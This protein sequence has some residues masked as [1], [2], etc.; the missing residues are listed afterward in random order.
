[1]YKQ[2]KPRGSRACTVC[3]LRKIRCDCEVKLPCSNCE[4]TGGQ[5]KI[6][7][8]KRQRV[9]KI[10]KKKDALTSIQEPLVPPQNLY[11]QYGQ[12]VVL[13]PLQNGP[14]R[15]GYVLGH[16]IYEGNAPGME[17]APG[18]GNGPNMVPQGV[19]ETFKGLPFA[20]GPG[21]YPI[22]MHSAQVQPQPYDRMM[23][24]HAPPMYQNGRPVE[25]GDQEYRTVREQAHIHYGQAEQ[26]VRGLAP[27][28]QYPSSPPKFVQNQPT[29][30]AFG[31]IEAPKQ[32]GPPHSTPPPRYPETNTHGLHGTPS[33][34]PTDTPYETAVE[35]PHRT[36]SLASYLGV[37]YFPGD[38]MRNVS[39]TTLLP[40]LLHSSATHIRVSRKQLLSEYSYVGPS[41][42]LSHFRAD[43]DARDIPEKLSESTPAFRSLKEL[44]DADF[45][46][47]LQ[48]LA[49]RRAFLLPLHELCLVLI[50]SFFEKVYPLCPMINRET[51]L[52]HFNDPDVSKRPPLILT[53]LI[54]MAGSRTCLH[55]AILDTSGSSL[56]ASRIFYERMKALYYSAIV[57]YYD[58]DDE[59]GQLAFSYPGV[60][61]A[62]LA[63]FAYYWDVPGEPTRGHC[64]WTAEALNV[65]IGY[66]FHRGFRYTSK[67]AESRYKDLTTVTPFLIRQQC[68]YWRKMFW[69]LFIR[70]KTALLSYGRPLF[71]SIKN[72]D[73][74]VLTLEDFAKYEAGWTN[75][76]RDILLAEYSVH[77]GRLAELTEVVWDETYSLWNEL[78]KQ[79]EKRRR[80]II[81]QCNSIMME[82]FAQLSTSL[83][84]DSTAS[85]RNIFAASVG[86]HYYCLLYHIN[87]LLIPNEQNHKSVSWGIAFQ[88]AFENSRI[89]KYLVDERERDPQVIFPALTIY[90][91]ALAAIVLSLH[92]DSTNKVVALAAAR[93]ISVCLKFIQNW[94]THWPGVSFM[95]LAYFTNQ[96]GVNEKR[97][98]LADKARR[99]WQKISQTSVTWEQMRTKTIDINFL[100]NSNGD[101]SDREETD[102][103]PPA[104]DMSFPVH[105]IRTFTA[106]SRRVFDAAA[107]FCKRERPVQNPGPIPRDRE[108]DMEMDVLFGF[109]DKE[110]D[111]K[112]GKK[113]RGDLDTKTD[114]DTEIK[115]ESM[116][117]KSSTP[118]TMPH[119]SPGQENLDSI[120]DYDSLD[121]QYF[122]DLNSGIEWGSS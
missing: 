101:P 6:A 34:T 13:Q 63:L 24:M 113:T 55:P 46:V 73:V 61:T 87:R 20:A 107:L 11:V 80:Q 86:M 8:V 26:L 53:M 50:D 94:S 38:T 12:P 97:Y 83:K 39:T 81:T 10:S 78:F 92:M 57:I 48:V 37:A 67:V 43:S 119:I 105:R 18:M 111:L 16:P 106:Q 114:P 121:N 47:E 82:F 62:S 3:R 64:F 35:S 1:M 29:F 112:A 58:G 84:F 52:R 98:A 70:D 88:A 116:E 36:S 117:T 7:E 41:S 77:S 27:P 56:T 17:S 5:C 28:N 99:L 42:C 19:G 122:L 115:S 60:L 14:M 90:S 44:S 75:L 45:E 104:T 110:V 103:L 65:A 95:L 4:W 40:S 71:I 9:N 89:A 51:F 33:Q 21:G 22:L 120:Y 91:T 23:P 66:G 32:P 31:P 118:K 72:M 69:W 109:D 74:E 2:R 79:D 76:D 93:Q 102:D 85:S 68:F 100:L 30:T 25:P 96:L 59:P 54:L 108:I 49:I 15:P